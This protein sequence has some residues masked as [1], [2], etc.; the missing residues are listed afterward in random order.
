MLFVNDKK[1]IFKNISTAS[2][3]LYISKHRTKIMVKI[4][5]DHFLVGT[6][7][8][9]SFLCHGNTWDMKLVIKMAAAILSFNFMIHLKKLALFLGKVLSKPKTESWWI[10]KLSKC[11]HH[12]LHRCVWVF[13][14][15]NG[16]E[17]SNFWLSSVW[18][19]VA[20]RTLLSC[21]SFSKITKNWWP[22]INKGFTKYGKW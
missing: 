7:Q 21:K 6:Y 19:N 3:L 1:T 16:V 13:W 17:I 22:K 11:L 20:W 14:V 18:R 4:I 10:K 12:E 2:I 15:R 5:H 9:A 8:V